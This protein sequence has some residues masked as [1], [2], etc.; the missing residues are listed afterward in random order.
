[1]KK[2][3]LSFALLSVCFGL[4]AQSAFYVDSSNTAATKNGLSWSTAYNNITQAINSSTIG[5]TIYIAKGTYVEGATLSITH[6]LTMRGGYPSGGGVA[7]DTSNHTIIDG[8]NSYKVITATAPNLNITLSHLT[9]QNG[10]KYGSYAS[11]MT[12]GSN[13]TIV[14]K[15]CK[16]K[17]NYAT[18]T[19]GVVIGG[20]IYCSSNT[21]LTM[22][23]CEVSGNSISTNGGATGAGI[24]FSGGSFQIIN[25]IIAKNIS[26]ASPSISG[27]AGIDI[28][29]I[30]DTCR[31]INS[32]ICDNQTNSGGSSSGAIDGN[33]LNLLVITNSVIAG[34]RVNGNLILPINASPQPQFR[35]T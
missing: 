20:G 18:S 5:D 12:F 15:F 3:F 9:I 17:N 28:Y 16:I 26:N 31:I 6:H 24:Y 2:L 27:T 7:Q 8:N 29:S 35:Y 10:Y 21:K 13:A 11:G 4:Y 32:L 1:M 23:N 33:G 34:N 19:N 25:S 14:L 30:T 22:V